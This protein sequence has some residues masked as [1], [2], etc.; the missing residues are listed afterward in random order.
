MRSRKGEFRVVRSSVRLD[1]SPVLYPDRSFF[2]SF[3]VLT[4]NDIA[5]TSSPEFSKLRAWLRQNPDV[6]KH[7]TLRHQIRPMDRLYHEKRQAHI[8]TQLSDGFALIFAYEQ[9]LH[10]PPRGPGPGHPFAA[11]AAIT[12]VSHLHRAARRYEVLS[13]LL[14]MEIETRVRLRFH[15]CRFAVAKILRLLAAADAVPLSFVPVISFSGLRCTAA[16]VRATD[17]HCIRIDAMRPRYKKMI[18]DARAAITAI[19]ARR[20]DAANFHTILGQTRISIETSRTLPVGFV[21]TR[22]HD[23]LCHPN[24]IVFPVLRRFLDCPTPENYRV[25]AA[26]L[27]HDFGIESY[28]ETMIIHT[29]MSRA[30][31]GTAAPQVR[32]DGPGSDDAEVLGYAFELFWGDDP[33]DL[34][35]VIGDR[36]EIMD[37]KGSIERAI[38]CLATITTGWIEILV[39]MYEFAFE[40]YLS[41]KANTIRFALGRV[42]A[43]HRRV[44]NM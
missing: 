22:F 18:E 2:D 31:A 11:G 15:I 41:A 25:L 44:A 40:E 26:S 33:I 6:S 3:P 43:E 29:L 39:F 8:K 19:A 21:P 34:Y 12:E 9:H 13:G 35:R 20:P 37:V 10:Q 4:C 1:T 32:A 38:A 16:D 30:F 17:P 24:T 36:L 28:E 42:L 5:S 7:V 23:F 27:V 14:R